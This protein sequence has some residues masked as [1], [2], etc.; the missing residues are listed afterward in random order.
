MRTA[1]RLW[2]HVRAS[3]IFRGRHIAR[4]GAYRKSS[5]ERLG[6]R[7]CRAAALRPEFRV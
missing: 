7:R 3:T 4:D 2:Y 1:S 5:G 6:R